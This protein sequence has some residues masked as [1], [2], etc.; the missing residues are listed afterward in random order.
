MLLARYA[1]HPLAWK[2]VI[3]IQPFA[4]H[5]KCSISSAFVCV[6]SH[7]CG[8]AFR[9]PPPQGLWIRPFKKKTCA[10]YVDTTTKPMYH[11]SGPFYGVLFYFTSLSFHFFFLRSS[12]KSKSLERWSRLERQSVEKVGGLMHLSVDCDDHFIR[13]Q[14]ISMSH[15]ESCFITGWPIKS[16]FFEMHSPVITS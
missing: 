4:F 13:P 10:F 3:N 16:R 14:H 5:Q 15:A 7:R 6:I 11:D 2:L 1:N 8:D 12:S 9:S